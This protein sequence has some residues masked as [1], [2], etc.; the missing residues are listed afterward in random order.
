I[1]EFCKQYNAATQQQSG[2]VVPVEITILEDRSFSFVLKTAPTGFLL[3]KVLGLEKGSAKP[4]REP[5]GELSWDQL[6]EV[7][8][9]KSKDLNAHDLE[10][11]TKIVAGS[12]RSMGIKING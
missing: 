12:A 2:E 1:M 7:A 11:A 4:G 10:Q 5:V 9:A 3:K 8:K 6:R